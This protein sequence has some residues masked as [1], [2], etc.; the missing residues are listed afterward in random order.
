MVEL[1][2]AQGFNLF[3]LKAIRAAPTPGTAGAA[4]TTALPR[5]PAYRRPSCAAPRLNSPAGQY[6]FKQGGNPDLDPEESD[7]FS[8]G[9][10]FTPRFAPGLACRST[11][12]TSRWKT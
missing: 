7:T 9:I 11:T 6:N 4:R 12:S 5:A 10:V 1:F 3:D 2:T 8:Y